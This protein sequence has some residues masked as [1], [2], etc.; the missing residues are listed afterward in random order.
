MSRL[1]SFIRRMEAQR[2]IL[3][4]V[5]ARLGDVPGTILEFGLGSGRTFDHLR[6]RFPGRHLIA[7]ENDPRDHVVDRLAPLELVL[8]DLRDTTRDLADG[9]AALIHIDLAGGSE[10]LD[11][12]ARTWLT[13]LAV[14]LLG[15]G[16]YLA[17][18]LALSDPRL[19]SQPLPSTIAPGRYHLSRRVT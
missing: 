10:H 19:A 15:V 1:D 17:S 3:N 11:H 8:G 13:P 9:S 7:F 5:S 4:L 6:E 16:G 18:D 14:R 12:E 2:D